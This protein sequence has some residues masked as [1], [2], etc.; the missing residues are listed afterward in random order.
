M[1]KRMDRE[2]FISLLPSREKNNKA[3]KAFIV[4][5]GE[6]GN[7][8]VVAVASEGN[9]YCGVAKRNPCDPPGDA[10]LNIAAC[11]A[12]RDFQGKKDVGYSRQHPVSKNQAKRIAVMDALDKVI[13]DFG[14]DID[15]D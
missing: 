13:D 14:L 6:P 10:G 15:I 12:W 3:D 11:R 1:L 9:L 8:T 5:S 4:F 2:V 7:F